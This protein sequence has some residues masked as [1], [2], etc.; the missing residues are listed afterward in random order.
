MA[1][2]EEYEFSA[3][4]CA[5]CKTLNPARKLRPIG[6]KIPG[7]GDEANKPLRSSGSHSQSDTSSGETANANVRFVH[8]E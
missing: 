6:P 7:V 5:F 2:L 3:F 4:C 8:H 1:T